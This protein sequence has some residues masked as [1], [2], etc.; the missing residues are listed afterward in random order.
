MSGPIQTSGFVVVHLDIPGVESAWQ[1]FPAVTVPLI[2]PRYTE[3]ERRWGSTHLTHADVRFKA[4]A[5]GTEWP[6]SDVYMMGASNDA[7]RSFLRDYPDIADDL[8]H[9]LV[10]L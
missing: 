1:I 10:G 2:T 8:W 5:R 6:Q 9:M 3:P 4:A 7:P